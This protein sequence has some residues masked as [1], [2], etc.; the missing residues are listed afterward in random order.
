[1]GLRFASL[2]SVEARSLEYPFSEEGVALSSLSRDKAL[3]LDHFTMALRHNKDAWVAD[4][5]EQYGERG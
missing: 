1:M 4:V 2:E 5:W 3:R